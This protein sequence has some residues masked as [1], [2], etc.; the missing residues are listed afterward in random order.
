M[1]NYPGYSQTF[2]CLSFPEWHHTWLTTPLFFLLHTGLPLLF[3]FFNWNRSF[4]GFLYLAPVSLYQGACIRTSL[5]VPCMAWAPLVMTFLH[6][7]CLSHHPEPLLSEGFHTPFVFST[8]CG[9]HSCDMER[10]LGCLSS[11]WT[12]WGNR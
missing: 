1:L 2:S 4:L 7:R 10:T 8:L 11:R 9:S 6:C 12:S 3:F 5:P